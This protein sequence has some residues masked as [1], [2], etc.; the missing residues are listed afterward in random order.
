MNTS[1][2]RFLIWENAARTYR[3][4]L[5]S[6]AG[7]L[8]ACLSS[9]IF[10]SRI[11]SVTINDKIVATEISYA[12]ITIALSIYVLGLLFAFGDERDLRLEMPRYLLRL[13]VKTVTLV[14]W[15][16]SYDV[17]SM[18]AL[19]FV[20]MMSFRIFFDTE[21]GNLMPFWGFITT[22]TWVVAA[23]RAVSWAVGRA[24]PVLTTL[25]AATIYVS[26]YQIL[27]GFGVRPFDSDTRM[28]VFALAVVSCAFMASIVTIGE[29]R[30]GRLEFLDELGDSFSGP[31]RHRSSDLP[32]FGSQ[33]QALRW[34][35]T[36]RQ[37]RIYPGLVFTLFAGIFVLGALKDV[38]A[39][40]TPYDF[41]FEVVL[42]VLGEV[43]LVTLYGS[44]A[45][46]TLLCSGIFLFQ[47]QRA[48]LSGAK[49][50]L[51]IRP[52]S[53]KS[54]A[55]ARLVAFLRSVAVTLIPIV[56]LTVLVFAFDLGSSENST[57]RG[58]I[59]HHWGWDG[60]VIVG[61]T[62]VGVATMLWVG[63]WLGNIL[64]FL[65]VF[66][67]PTMVIE[68]FPMFSEIH[69]FTRGVYALRVTAVLG[70]GTAIVLFVAAKRRGLLE[71]WSM[72]SALVALPFL[73]AGF[74]MCLNANNMSDG[75]AMD[76]SYLGYTV[77]AL[78]LLPI[79]PLLTVPLVMDWARH[80]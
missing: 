45:I 25:F 38:V 24:G 21:T 35:E 1:A 74:L 66:S 63:L 57:F 17:V 31:R 33:A 62:L 79:A 7:V 26:V 19:A 58:F 9:Y 46:G 16:L 69:E 72:A 59:D 12:G 6:L 4:W 29:H 40:I 11:E 73:A 76:Y 5:L 36:R 49:T 30:K 18:A 64:A 71:K 44:L 28:A 23:L 65:I 56:L 50:F 52:A 13:P 8:G 2:I 43:I 47:N 68:Y 51:F 75:L 42:V 67:L 77:P 37:T 70:L 3:L 10:L 34:Y 39:F 20:S 14:F 80:R 32:P 15:R 55:L 78:I 53:T 61:L 22:F 60:L 54:L 27:E 48:Q 41:S